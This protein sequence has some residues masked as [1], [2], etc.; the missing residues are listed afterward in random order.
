MGFGRF[1]SWVVAVGAAG[2]L[3]GCVSQARAGSGGSQGGAGP[4]PVAQVR[5]ARPTDKLDEVVRFYRDGVGLPEIGSFS[6]HAGYDGVMLGLPD[7]S[8]HL[9]FTRHVDGSPGAAPSRDNLLVLYIP[10]RAERMRI[11]QR[12]ARMGYPEVEPENP[13]WK[14]KSV[15]IADPD[16]YRVVLFDGTFGARPAP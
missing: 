5:V 16:G 13:Y 10:D 12:L 1:F 3:A 4:W 14:G 9:E 11:A 2:F 6:G 7:A 15:T 8:I